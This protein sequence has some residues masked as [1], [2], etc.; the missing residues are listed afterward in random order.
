MGFRRPKGLLLRM[1]WFLI[2]RVSKLDGAREIS[3]NN[4]LPVQGVT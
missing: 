3:F 1:W 2:G 4:D